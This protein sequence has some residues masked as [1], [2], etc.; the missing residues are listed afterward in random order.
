M[1]R[2]STELFFRLVSCTRISVSQWP[3]WHCWETPFGIFYY[4]LFSYALIY[5][6]YSYLWIQVSPLIQQRPPTVSHQTRMSTGKQQYNA[7]HCLSLKFRIFSLDEMTK[8][9]KDQID[10]SNSDL[11]L[12]FHSLSLENSGKLARGELADCF[13]PCTPKGVLQLIKRTGKSPMQH[14]TS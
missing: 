11:R 4:F 9:P 3:N 6:L 5:A 10:T 1:R 2:T 8:G 13:L 7:W 12:S 14:W